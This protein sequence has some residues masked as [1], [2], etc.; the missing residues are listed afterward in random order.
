M[1]FTNFL[2]TVS[3]VCA[4]AHVCGGV[5]ACVLQFIDNSVQGM[6]QGIF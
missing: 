2:K 1:L 3:C 5:H 4:Y 6:D